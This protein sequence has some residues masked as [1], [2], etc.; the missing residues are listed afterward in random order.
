MKSEVSSEIKQKA[1]G[2]MAGARPV[3]LSCGSRTLIAPSSSSATTSSTIS[4]V[5][6][7]GSSDLWGEIPTGTPRR[8]YPSIT[9]TDNPSTICSRN[10]ELF[11]DLSD[12]SIAT[13]GSSGERFESCHS[14]ASKIGTTRVNAP[15]SRKK[16]AKD[17]YIKLVASTYM[18]MITKTNDLFFRMVM[19]PQA[20]IVVGP[21]KK[22][23]ALP[24]DLLSYYSPVFER[25]LYGSFIEVQTQIME[26]PEDDVE[27]FEILVDY[28][29]HH[30]VVDKLS[31]SKNGPHV[32]ERCISFLKYADLYDLGDV[33]TLVYDA[34]R[35]ALIDGGPSAF[36]SSFIEVVFSLTK[37]GSCLRALMADAALSFQ[38]EY[39]E[40]HPNSVKISFAKQEAEVEGFGLALYRQLK[41]PGVVCV[42]ESPFDPRNYKDFD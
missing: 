31:I 5:K 6:R 16:P 3:H 24:I 7:K 8:N 33:S 1:T 41:K 2:N 14:H 19:G 12:N 36:K 27:N 34:L 20:N 10:S 39:L 13:S 11:S 23:F 15:H 18:A 32:A 25:A 21:E 30:S 22:S 26:L 17:L 38:G 40:S 37:D 35:S 4:G 29:F 9:A 42:Y 28:I